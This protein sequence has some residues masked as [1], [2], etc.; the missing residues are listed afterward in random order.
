MTVV[1]PATLEDVEIAVHQ[2]FR[3]TP[4]DLRHGRRQSQVYARHV[5]YYVA[6]QK[7]RFSMSEIGDHVGTTT[8]SVSHSITKLEARRSDTVLRADIFGVGAI[9]DGDEVIPA[10]RGHVASLREVKGAA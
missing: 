9:V 7:T 1:L 3:T 4:A 2:Y 6:R 5:F 8:A 10:G